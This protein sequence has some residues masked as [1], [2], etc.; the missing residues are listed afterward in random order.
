MINGHIP[1]TSVRLDRGEE[2]PQSSSANDKSNQESWWPFSVVALVEIP[3]KPRPNRI[4]EMARCRRSCVLIKLKIQLRLIQSLWSIFDIVQT[5]QRERQSEFSQI[6]Q[7]YILEDHRNPLD[8]DTF[9]NVP[10]HLRILSINGRLRRVFV[11]THGVVGGWL[12]GGC[13]FACR[14]W[15]V[16]PTPNLYHPTRGWAVLICIPNVDDQRGNEHG[17]IYG[18]K[19]VQSTG[20]YKMCI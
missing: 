13:F 12:A 15:S 2:P 7:L 19:V 17:L 18:S 20:R 6:E 8:D 14:C 4:E 9:I 3:G 11:K 10:A 5:S 1:R 16:C